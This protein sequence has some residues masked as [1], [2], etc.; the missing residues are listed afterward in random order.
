MGNSCYLSI[1]AIFRCITS[2]FALHL[3]S[4]TPH[5]LPTNLTSFAPFT[6]TYPKTCFR[7]TE[8]PQPG[9]QATKCRGFLSICWEALHTSRLTPRTNEWV[10]KDR[11]GCAM[12][13][14]LPDLAAA[15]DD[16]SCIRAFEKLVEQC[17]HDSRFNGGGANVMIMPR[18]GSDGFAIDASR[19]RFAFA[20]TV[21]T[22]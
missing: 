17:A 13:F 20:P 16:G 8:P 4:Y 7:I 12:G 19:A 5:I 21:L 3:P 2:T 15:P 22:S 11:G 14:F 9:L 1:L 6:A 18:M 10:W